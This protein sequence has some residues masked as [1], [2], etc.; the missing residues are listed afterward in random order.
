[1]FTLTLFIITV[2]AWLALELW[3]VLRGQQSI[4]GRIRDVF[5]RWPTLGM[6]TG[7]VVG[8]LLGHLFFPV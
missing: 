2:A 8:I 3:F 7:L 4:S 6:L 1:M 5:V